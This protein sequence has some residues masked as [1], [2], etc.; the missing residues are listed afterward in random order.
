MTKTLND[1]LTIIIT[2][3]TLLTSCMDK[4]Q[5]NSDAKIPDD[6]IAKFNKHEQ[7]VY[8]NA[9]TTNY[10]PTKTLEVGDRIELY[11]GYD[12]DPLYLKNPPSSTRTGVVT[13][14]ITGQNESLAAIV[15]LDS[16]I[17][18]D[19]ITGDIL[20]LEL[21]Y[22]EQNWFT[23]GP[24]HIELCN[25]ELDNKSW[26]DRPKGEWVEAAASFRIIK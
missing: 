13:K 12:Y 25:F 20:V 2:F 15:K 26:K 4:N 6:F 24:V 9:D 23:T 3:T 8:K 1:F 16:K 18:G 17:S 21:R 11:G 7:E 10:Q 5:S 22:K 14:F 19:S